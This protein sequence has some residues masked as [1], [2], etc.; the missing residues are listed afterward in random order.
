M[1]SSS[2]QEALW[3]LQLPPPCGLVQVPD[4]DV[5]LTVPLYLAPT[6]TAPNLIFP[7]LTLPP[8]SYVP[9]GF[10]RVM[11]PRSREPVFLQ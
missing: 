9:C 6:L 3:A 5:P 4:I 11:L 10:E 2:R 7:L 8:M 1:V